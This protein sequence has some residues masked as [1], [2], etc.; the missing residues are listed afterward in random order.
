MNKAVQIYER[1][2]SAEPG[3]QELFTRLINLYMNQRNFSTVIKRLQ[4]IVKKNP[5][6]SV[7]TDTL[8]YAYL[9]L[10]RKN[11]YINLYKG[12]ADKDSK[13]SDSRIRYAQALLE[14]GKKKEALKEMEKALKIDPS[15]ISIREQIVQIEYALGNKKAAEKQLEEIKKIEPNYNYEVE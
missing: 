1:L 13:S 14:Q 6:E 12:I 2:S 15:N 11:D 7:F 5:K 8:G 9:G 4:P 3:N 10:G